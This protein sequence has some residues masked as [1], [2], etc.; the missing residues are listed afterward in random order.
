MG[1]VERINSVLEYKVEINFKR[2]KKPEK[3]SREESNFERLNLDKRINRNKTLAVIGIF[4]FLLNVA[5]FYIGK[6]WFWIENKSY[7]E[8]KIGGLKQILKEHPGA[9]DVQVEI[10]MTNYLNGDTKKAVNQLRNILLK[11]S[12]NNNAK[13]ILGVILSERK[14]TNESIVL[15]SE[16]VKENQGLETRI[17]Y[18]YLGQNYLAVGNYDLALRN[19]TIASDRDPGNPVV[20][21][22]LG[23]TYE[24][25]KKTKSAIQSYEKALE[26]NSGYIEADRAL[27]SLIKKAHKK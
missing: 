18:L 23:Q 5:G 2:R 24:K 9:K 20:Y 21:Y 16:Y 15:L 3:V 22:F 4:I 10:A 1:I 27:T 25:L 6:E 12:H 19:L 13:F 26:I 14:E 11:D 17:A 7:Y 8:N